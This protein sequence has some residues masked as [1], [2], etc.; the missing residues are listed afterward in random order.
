MRH[1]DVGAIDVV[2][3][4]SSTAFAPITLGHE[5]AGTIESVGANVS[6]WQAGN[7]AAV[8]P[9]GA[10]VPGFTGHGGYAEFHLVNAS[11]LVPV[12]DG[13][14]D[15]HAAI[16]TDAGM[17]LYHTAVHSAGATAG[18]HLGI[19]RI[20]GLASSVLRS[21]LRWA[22]PC[23]QS[24]PDPRAR[25]DAAGWGLAGIGASAEELEGHDLDAVIDFAGFEST[26]Q[27]ALRS[28]KIGGMVGMGAWGPRTPS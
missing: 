9:K 3:W 12:P 21:P 6:D 10:I 28:I 13:V 24:N 11:D 20:G 7:R 25:E 27:Y 4:A 2:T 8:H 16:A 23:T 17:T 18:S 19:I 26:A 1:T 22:R 14:S 15:A 5:I